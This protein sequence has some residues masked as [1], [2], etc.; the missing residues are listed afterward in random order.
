MSPRNMYGINYWTK[1]D[2]SSPQYSPTPIP[3]LASLFLLSTLTLNFSCPPSL[4]LLFNP[5]PSGRQ[6]PVGV[7][8]GVP[9]RASA[10]VSQ[11]VSASR[12]RL[13]NPS[14]ITPYPSHVIFALQRCAPCAVHTTAS[15][16]ACRLSGAPHKVLSGVF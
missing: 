3:L 1:K 10:P 16:C 2:D 7:L 15:A 14:R 6:S 9:P 5:H 8:C 11:S 4:S 13:S 12:S